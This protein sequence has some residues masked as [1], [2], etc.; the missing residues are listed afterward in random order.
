MKPQINKAASRPTCQRTEAL[1]SAPPSG[2]SQPWCSPLRT[3]RA[4][5]AQS[6]CTNR[7]DC[8][9]HTHDFH[10]ILR[11]GSAA[12]RNGRYRHYRLVCIMRIG[13]VAICH[14]FVSLPESLVRCTCNLLLGRGS[15]LTVDQLPVR[16]TSPR[17]TLSTSSTSTFSPGLTL[18]SSRRT[19]FNTGSDRS[20]APSVKRLSASRYE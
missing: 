20:T 17:R 10:S 7:S 8:Q 6:Q 5:R 1:S 3:N 19:T 16:F 18:R 14:F 13:G 4:R 12:R 2:Q 11:K 15:F 9:H